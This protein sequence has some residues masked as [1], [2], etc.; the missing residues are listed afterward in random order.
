MHCRGPLV[1]IIKR[2]HFGLSTSTVQYTH[3]TDI[4]YP[5]VESMKTQLRV[6]QMIIL[7]NIVPNSYI[8]FGLCSFGTHTVGL[9]YNFIIKFGP[10]VII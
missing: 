4:A 6:Y 1:F 5:I 10:N 2:V 7:Y 8:L 3:P 9:S